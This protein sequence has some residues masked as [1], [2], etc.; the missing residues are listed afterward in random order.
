MINQMLRKNSVQITSQVTLREYLKDKQLFNE[1]LS[2][3]QDRN[4]MISKEEL[5]KYMKERNIAF[6]ASKLKQDKI[7]LVDFLKEYAS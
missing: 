7:K 6:D 3:D 4:G 2:I 1:T 5:L